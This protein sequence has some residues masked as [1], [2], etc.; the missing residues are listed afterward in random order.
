RDFIERFDGRLSALARAHSLLV[1]SEWKGADLGELARIQLEP[2]TSAKPD[3]LRVAGEP[4]SLPAD[5]AT[6]FSL[7][8]HEL[9]TNAAKYGSLSRP[10]GIITVNWTVN[11]RN[12]RRAMILVWQE[13]AGPAV[14]SPEAVG[15]GTSL[16]ENA[17]PGATVRR[18]FRPDGLVCSIEVP[19]PES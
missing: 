7:V 15:L 1:K 14:K 12:N 2:Y 6:P 13:K 9:A 16:I 17:I 11:S 10:A 5:L 8:L 18:E 3:R 19:L 4:L